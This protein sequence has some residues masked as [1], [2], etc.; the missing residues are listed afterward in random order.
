M[1]WF[2]NLKIA[3]KLIIGFIIVAIIAGI[4][5][6]I[7]FIG[8]SDMSKA[9][10]EIGDVR[11]PSIQSLLN[12]YQAQT[13]VKSAERTMFSQLDSKEVYDKQVGN[14][15]TEFTKAE[16][17]WKIY[18][19][20]PQTKEEAEVWKQFVTSWDKWKGD[21]NHFDELVQKY[22]AMN[23]TNT[24]ER[25]KLF[26]QIENQSL[27]VAANSF[28]ET[29]T[30]L[31]NT[32]DLNKKEADKANIDAEKTTNT[33]NINL[34]I[35]IAIGVVSAISLGLFISNII[36]KPI[37][38]MSQVA[39]KLAVGDVKVNVE[40]DSKDEIG[41]LAKSFGKMIDNIRAQATAAEKIATGDL[42]VDIAIKSENDLLGKKLSEMVKNNNEILYNIASA[43]DQVSSGAKQVSDSSMALSQGATEQASSIE[44]LT[45]SIEEISSQTRLNAQNA[46]NANELANTA[47]SNAMQGND[48]MKDMLKAIEEIN[49]SSNN[50]YKI[51]KVIDDI[52]FQTNI[53]ALNAAVEAA[54]AGQH[55]KG[56]AV[57]AEEVR[58]LA[59]RSAKA[60]KET[61]DMIESS[62]KKAEGG[63]KI[64]RDTAGALNEIV[65]GI[66]KVAVLVNDIAIAS[67]EQATGISQINQGIMQVSQVVQ[68]NSA[69]SEESAAAS[70]ELSSQAMLLKEM[71][72]K[73]KLKQNTRNFSRIDD[74]NPD[75]LKM[76]ENM[77]ESKKTHEEASYDSSSKSRIALSDK[78]FGKY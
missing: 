41:N 32:I 36:S 63:T 60:A 53:L 76:L 50:I 8:L 30:L 11:L 27:T 37:K 66:E 15:N 6:Y 77:S 31:L 65:G 25:N 29:E 40:F 2:Y 9:V 56:F 55:G 4:V 12:I 44:E 13:A 52:A 54:R 73:Y 61:T 3:A 42:T 74:F 24:T 46:N 59:A 33:A 51:I 71:V 64:A 75:V 14:I 18:E 1:K 19:P 17:A 68:A 5:G 35:A 78:E 38:Q 48:Q 45:A 62:I 69:T 43:S 70:E 20:L 57:V 23:P 21:I 47:K 10:N 49:E 39:D 72:G 26:L 34:L 7:G 58:N 67:N 28:R 16:N 22:Q